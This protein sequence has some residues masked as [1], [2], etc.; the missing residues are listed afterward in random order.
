MQSYTWFFSLANPLTEA[1]EAA[2][3]GDFQSF[4]D[5][6][7]SHGTPV[8][9]LIQVRH[10]RFVIAQ[11]NPTEARPS[12]CSIDSLRRGIEQILGQHQLPYLDPSQ[13]SFRSG[14]GEIETVDFRQIPALVSEGRLQASTPVFDHSL[15]HTDDL[16]KWEVPMHTTWLSRYLSVKQ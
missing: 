16:S 11:A 10:K 12:G 5:Q 4:T 8:T 3:L 15:S 1:Q 6:W 9:G 13:V 2:L 7:K 14:T